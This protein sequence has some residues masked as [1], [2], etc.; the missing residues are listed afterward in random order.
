MKTSIDKVTQGRGAQWIELSVGEWNV[1]AVLT[2]AGDISVFR[3]WKEGATRSTPRGSKTWARV[4]AAA[5]TAIETSEE[6]KR[7]GGKTNE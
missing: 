5:K 2:K 1:E 4:A 3:V 7:L 6:I